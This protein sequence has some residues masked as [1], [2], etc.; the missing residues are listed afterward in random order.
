MH[1]VLLYFV[2]NSF[3]KE[4][5]VFVAC[6]RSSV[7]DPHGTFWPGVGP[8]LLRGSSIRNKCYFVIDRVPSGLQ[9]D[10]DERF[11]LGR[12][13]YNISLFAQHNSRHCVLRHDNGWR[14]LDGNNLLYDIF[15]LSSLEIKI[16]EIQY[17]KFMFFVVFWQTYFCG[18]VFEIFLIFISFD[19][20]KRA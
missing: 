12:C 15:I 16:N 7:S 8:I 18:T 6:K 11:N 19:W 5:W 3:Y 20:I 13:V 1:Y 4:C 10:P 2:S 9:G 14:R 17:A